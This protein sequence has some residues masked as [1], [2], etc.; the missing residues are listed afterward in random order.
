MPKFDHFSQRI[1]FYG[2]LTE[3]LNMYQNLILILVVTHQF[4]YVFLRYSFQFNFRFNILS[5]YCKTVPLSRVQS[6]FEFHFGRSKQG[7]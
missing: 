7:Y 6:R 3:N 2:F 4:I 1:E 5:R